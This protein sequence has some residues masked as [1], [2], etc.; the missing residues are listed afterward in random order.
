M[1]A[2]FAA[3]LILSV[4][5]RNI[6]NDSRDLLQHPNLLR[7]NQE[8]LGIQGTFVYEKN[9]VQLW[10]RQLS[11]SLVAAVLNTND[12]MPRRYLLNLKDLSLKGSKVTVT[13]VFTEAIIGV[14]D[15]TEEIPLIVNPTGVRLLEFH[16]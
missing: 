16:Q 10:Q 1:W 7:I 15:P 13:D 12:D 9:N 8:P 5:L 11:D 4:D 6:A 2:I 3:P 14:F